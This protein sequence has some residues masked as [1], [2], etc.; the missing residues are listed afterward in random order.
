[1]SI[2]QHIV[3]FKTRTSTTKRFWGWKKQNKQINNNNPV[4]L[5]EKITILNYFRQRCSAKNKIEIKQKLAIIRSGTHNRL[6]QVNQAQR[7]NRLRHSFLGV[8]VA[9]HLF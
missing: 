7:A 4:L 6:Q 5:A 2:V 9:K 3:Y 8:T 1:M